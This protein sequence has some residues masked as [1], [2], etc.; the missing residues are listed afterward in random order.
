M[1]LPDPSNLDGA[2][3]YNR[4]GNSLSDYLVGSRRTVGH[5]EMRFTIPGST[6]YPPSFPWRMKNAS[7]AQGC[8]VCLSA[9]RFL[10]RLSNLPATIQPRPLFRNALA[11][12]RSVSRGTHGGHWRGP[13][14]AQR[15]LHGGGERRRL[16]N[17]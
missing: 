4:R 1:K 11:L 17:H 2:L 3:V 10:L 5:A 6:R 14:T 15:F 12:D 13:P 7:F 9:G 8:R 16:E